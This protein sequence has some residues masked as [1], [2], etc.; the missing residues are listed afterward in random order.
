MKFSIRLKLFIIFSGLILFFV[1]LS[2]FMNSQFLDKYYF[3][4]KKHVLMEEYHYINS[5]YKG[6]PEEVS[7]ELEKLE[8]MK[9]M[10]IV[11]FERESFEVKYSSPVRRRDGRQGI[12]PQVQARGNLFDGPFSQE[13]LIKNRIQNMP[14]GEPVIEKSRDA[15]LN[16]D[17]I[18]LLSLLDNEDYI[19]IGTPVAA[20]DESVEI[21]NKFLLFTGIVTMITGCLI[22]LFLTGR[23]TRPILELNEIAKKMSRLDFGSRYSVSSEDEIGELGKNINSLSQQLEKSISELREANEK[24]KADIEKERQ[25]DEM[26]KEFV[27]NVSHELKTPIALI[28]GYAEGLKVNV[29]DDED[30][31]NFY[32]EVIM[33]EAQRMN[34][35][36]KQLLD[37]SQLESGYTHLERIDFNL[38]EFIA[39]ILKKNSLVLKKNGVEVLFENCGEIVVNADIY[40]IE[41]VLMNYINNAVNHVN[42]KKIVKISAVVENNSARVIVYNSGQHISEEVGNKMW[43]SFYKVDKA[44]TRMYGGTGLGLSIVRAI[45]EAHG[46]GYGFNNREGGVEFWFELELSE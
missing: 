34:R 30:N 28:Q 24:L 27:S 41:Q 10:H 18:T 13:D 4:N 29:N 26:R 22:V 20:I 14:V 31:K 6:D 37:L 23:L 16:S 19:L 32:C 11:I 5:L 25:I 44:R 35:L 39:A 8:R 36:V 1:M 3:Y 2:W 46:K 9:G 7:L 12:P 17:F 21:A 45:Q 40:R 42:D 43:T 33:D 15:R 38:V